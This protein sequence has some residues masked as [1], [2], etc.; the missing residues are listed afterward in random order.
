MLLSPR[1]NGDHARAGRPINAAEVAPVR[2]TNVRRFMVPMLVVSAALST[3]LAAQ[4]AALGFAATV[5]GRWQLEGVDIGYRRDAHLGPFRSAAI[6]ARLGSFIDEGAI[7]GGA[8]GVVGGLWISSRTGLLHVADVGNET[9]PSAFGIDLTIEAVGYA[10]SNSPLPQGSSWAAVS[11]LPGVR[12][13]D[14]PGMRFGLVVGP[15]VFFGSVTDVRA[16]LGLR[17]DL[18][19]TR[20]KPSS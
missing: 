18:P 16:F 15:T 14:G 20:R 10:G 17:F 9:N 3:P 4:S 5:G 13:G 1:R 19:V 11:V 8:R 12:L 7:V 6:G 2:R